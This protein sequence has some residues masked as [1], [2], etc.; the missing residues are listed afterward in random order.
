M[1]KYRYTTFRTSVPENIDNSGII[2]EDRTESLPWP[3][4]LSAV[5]Q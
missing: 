3:Q 2:Y 4:R 5:V 1:E